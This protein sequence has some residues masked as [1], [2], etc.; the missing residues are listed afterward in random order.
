MYV[1][2]DAKWTAL[3]N[4]EAIQYRCT[5]KQLQD[6][7]GISIICDETDT[8]GVIYNGTKG[9]NG[10]SVDT[11]A[12]YKVIKDSLSA[13]TAKNQSGMDSILKNLSTATEKF[14]EEISGNTCAIKDTVRDNEIAIFTV[15]IQ[16]GKDETEIKSHSR[17]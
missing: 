9:Q 6:K 3:S 7:S 4:E 10:I 1:C 13:A 14:K 17:F 5:S 11:A 8:I 15:T 2:T 12:I 16:C